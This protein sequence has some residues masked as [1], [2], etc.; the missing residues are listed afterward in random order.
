MSL[1]EK[2]FGPKK[3]KQAAGLLP[4]ADRLQPGFY[5]MERPAL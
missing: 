3:Q 5:I 4:D 1:L 2:I